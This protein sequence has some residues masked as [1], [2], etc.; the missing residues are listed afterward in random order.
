MESQEKTTSVRWTS[1][2]Q[3]VIDS[4]D[5]NLLVSAAAGSGKTAVLVERI[6]QMVTNEKN[7][8]DID[9]LLIVT[10]TNAAAAE[11]RER[12]SAAIEKKLQEEPENE[13]LQ[14]QMTLV[15][16]AQIT[17][18]HS[19]CQSVIRNNFN[20]I[21]LDPT[22]RIAEE[23]ELTLIKSDVIA[24][25]LE[26]EY[27]KGEE[28][29]LRLVDSY[30]N[31][32][33]DKPIEDLILQLYR[34][35]ISY[36]WPE[37]WLKGL[38]QVFEIKDVDEL[39]E[40]IFMK[41]LLEYVG[42]VLKDVRNELH[43]ALE[44][45]EQCD[46]PSTYIDNLTDD[47]NQIDE[48]LELT[49][50]EEYAKGLGKIKFSALSRKKPQNEVDEEIKN[51]VKTLRDHAKETIKKLNEGY[52]FQPL[53]QML[54]D[55]VY[56][57]PVMEELIRLTLTF[58]ERYQA[59][60]SEKLILDFNDLEHFALKILV[61]KEGDKIT[62][63]AVAK[64]L[65]EYYEE[66]MVDEYQ[67]S[68]LVQETILNSIS[69]ER[70][71]T[72]NIFMVGDVKQSIYKF[73][74]A[75][76]ELFMEKYNTYSTEENIYQRIDLH[77]NFRSRKLVLDGINYIFEQIMTKKL[78]NIEYDADAALY[79]GADFK[80]TDELISTENE[81]ILVT[82]SEENEDNASNTTAKETSSESEEDEE[83]EYSKREME[84]KAVAIRI[85]E[86]IEGDEPIHVFDKKGFYRPATYKDVVILLRTM[87]GW[88]EV[89]VDVLLSEGVP[90]YADTASG[91]FQTLEIKTIL[92]MLRIIDNPLQDI[93]YTAI[94]HSPIG[95]FENEEL[96]ILRETNREKLMH[97]VVEAYAETTGENNQKL[98]EK[99]KRFLALL[100]DLREREHYLSIHELI[101]YF[102][103]QTHY[104]DF[105]SAM[106]AGDVRK[107]NV[108]MLVK[109]A[110][111]FESTSYS[112]LF[113]F[114]R[115]IEK[116]QK[117]EID[118]GEA[119]VSNENDNTV[120]I[121][122]IHKSKGLEF[123][124][125]FVSGMG[126][127]FNNQDARK[128]VVFH[129]EMGIGPD[130]IDLELRVK[131][132]TLIKKVIQ[133]MM[134]LENLGEEL[135]VLYVALTRAKEK[136]IMT[137]YVDNI[138]KTFEKYQTI[139]QQ[140]ERQL[141]YLQLTS[142][143][144]FLDYILSA[145]I[146]HKTIYQQ[147][148]QIINKS[149]QSNVTLEDKVPFCLR[150]ITSD[151]LVQKE[152][153]KQIENEIGKQTLLEWDSKKCYNESIRK[154]M[155]SILE[156][157]YPFQKET[158]LR[159]K[160]TVSELKRLSQKDS[161]V[162]SEVLIPEELVAQE[163][164]VNTEQMEKTEEIQNQVPQ[165]FEPVIPR[166]MKKEEI[167]SGA[168]RGT[169]YHKILEEI[170]LFSMTSKEEI[171]EKIRELIAMDK[172]PQET[173]EK[174]NVNQL[175]AF[176]KSNLCKRMRR[177]Y[178]NKK[179]YREQQFV[180]GI[181]AKEINPMYVSDEIMLVQGII[182]VFFEE[183]G[184]LV[185]MDYKT[186]YVR[187]RDGRELIDKY[188][189]QL[190]YYKRALEQMTEMKVKESIIYSFALNQ[191]IRLP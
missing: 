117:Y 118:F 26:E 57:K 28:G 179:L 146:R 90:A 174:I 175:Y 39:Q 85:K 46:G 178:E 132:P 12:I 155:K 53:E 15:H 65:S 21:D 122:S 186:D 67:D 64:E 153:K 165:V 29:F 20:V 191:E 123:P 4:R 19:F 89:F 49:T 45:C 142:A 25:L 147:F 23:A 166:F 114:V 140:T 95:G 169:L 55:I 91:Y 63:T 104:Y 14:K 78:G 74:L 77:K 161:D 150:V 160:I 139:Y 135:R 56:M 7:P 36:P 86:L 107:A 6:I 157:Q 38:I 149:S 82:L 108:D 154:E 106:P 116:L 44:L 84:A 35:S 126:K 112:G 60:K 33:T 115:Y 68:N 141:S 127:T 87:S 130:V 73:R 66:I 75:R 128:S 80:E 133:K 177:A 156:Y 22:A 189:V 170:N 50:Y 144:T 119:S 93:P 24:E 134:V 99:C 42:E 30:S 111:S 188:A 184:E 120:R 40:Q 163:E 131:A 101:L 124:I 113:Q 92:N 183:D 171:M 168:A 145:L 167:I 180:L 48:L 43:Q 27:E 109:R 1:E 137:G 76:P 94:L 97:H 125:V 102:L 31:A 110:I 105:V 16:S 162:E 172:L 54:E 2:Q 152:Q 173:L 8:I 52:F 176:T 100:Q 182:D 59:V 32:K 37:E 69:K 79:A 62:P 138:K 88:A 18:T 34:F 158:E 61:N 70:L 151:Q 71:G 136:L 148:K 164:Q 181:Q 51:Q 11:M 41:S 159:A 187:S 190:D 10:F 98:Q 129:P 47:C 9:H 72:P 121:M 103:E 58:L 185:L 13:H 83:E 143:N 3:K 96:A 5:R 17:T 81:L